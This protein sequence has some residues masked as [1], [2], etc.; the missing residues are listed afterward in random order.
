[1][2]I[3]HGRASERPQERLGFQVHLSN[4]TGLSGKAPHCR[5]SLPKFDKNLAIPVLSDTRWRRALTAAGE[6]A[7]QVSMSLP[8]RKHMIVGSCLIC[9]VSTIELIP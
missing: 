8:S 7:S 4:P 2:A 9:D 5:V 6:L 1:M 3:A